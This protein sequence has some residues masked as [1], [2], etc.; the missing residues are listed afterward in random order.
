MIRS[1]HTPMHNLYNYEWS[2][3]CRIVTDILSTLKTRLASIILHDCKWSFNDLKEIFYASEVGF[4]LSETLTYLYFQLSKFQQ[5]PVK[6]INKFK[7]KYTIS[8]SYEFQFSHYHRRFIWSLTLGPR[9]ISQGA[10][11]LT[12]TPC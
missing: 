6:T 12:R 7:Y 9:E 1:L 5:N 2:I 11:K 4:N 10:R 3:L 8:N